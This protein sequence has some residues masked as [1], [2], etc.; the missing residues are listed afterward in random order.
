MATHPIVAKAVHDSVL[1]FSSILNTMCYSCN[2]E[3]MHNNM[4]V[5][6]CSNALMNVIPHPSLQGKVDVALENLCVL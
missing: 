6:L 3:I 4:L 1:V 2:Y 5:C